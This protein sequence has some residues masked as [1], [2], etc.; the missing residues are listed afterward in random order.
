MAPRTH[1]HRNALTALSIL[2][3]CAML[4]SAAMMPSTAEAGA[5]VTVV[6]GDD[7]EGCWSLYR[8]NTRVEGGCDR[9]RF[10]VGTGSYTL[11]TSDRFQ[12]ISFTVSDR[13]VTVD[14]LR[15]RISGGSSTASSSSSSS[16]S[17]SRRPGSSSTP[18]SSHAFNGEDTCKEWGI[19]CVEACFTKGCMDQCVSMTSECT[20]GGTPDYDHWYQGCTSV[21]RTVECI[22]GCKDV[23]IAGIYMSAAR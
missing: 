2:A 15:G 13:D 8:G 16:N 19:S 6:W 10:A 14:P 18:S 3:G 9:E 21:C 1:S 11:K 12:P 4:A 7:Y 17:S 20:R 23:A 22:E 5:Y